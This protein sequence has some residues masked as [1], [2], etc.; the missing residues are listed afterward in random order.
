[1][2]AFEK[3]CWVVTLLITCLGAWRLF[4]LALQAGVSAPQYAAE[5]AGIC[6]ML[7]VPYVFSRA[8][9]GFRDGVDKS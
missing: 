1:M 7:L 9:Q 2:R 4:N 5:A 6:A 8:V 3:F